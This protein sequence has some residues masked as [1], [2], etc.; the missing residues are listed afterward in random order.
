MAMQAPPEN[1]SVMSK[2][3]TELKDIRVS[4]DGRHSWAHTG[5][6]RQIG[7]ARA[8]GLIP[9]VQYLAGES[10]ERT[11][12]CAARGGQRRCSISK[13]PARVFKPPAPRGVGSPTGRATD[14]CSRRGGAAATT[15]PFGASL[16]CRLSS[17][18]SFNFFFPS[19]L[20]VRGGGGLTQVAVWWLAR[21][22]VC[23]QDRHFKDERFE[24]EISP[25]ANLDKAA[26]LQVC[27]NSY[28][29]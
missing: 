24:E 3:M 5:K 7:S 14:C 19:D 8:V 28:C 21:V 4:L 6:P 18:P 22:R 26:V 17:L 29:V 20:C 15:D 10:G 1:Q 11:S 23:V 12:S 13:T 25:F 27:I 9:G 16:R 2:I